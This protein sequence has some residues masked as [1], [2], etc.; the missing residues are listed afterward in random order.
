MKAH[1]CILLSIFAVCKNS[2]AHSHH[3]NQPHHRRTHHQ[4]NS[5]D[6]EVQAIARLTH[7]LH[8]AI[9][10]EHLH[11]HSVKDFL[12]IFRN[13][14]QWLRL[15]NFHKITRRTVRAFN[16]ESDKRGLANHAKNLALLFPLSHFIE[17]MTAPAF[18]A[19]GTI[20]ELPSIVIGFGGS[21]LSIIA[22]PGLDPLCI[23]LL[24]AYPFKPVHRSIDFIRG[25]VEK[26]VR[27]TA[28]A[29][30]L[31][32]LLSKTFTYKDRFHLI[33]KEFSEKNKL[34]RL[35]DIELTDFEGGGGLSI[36][37]KKN[38]DKM[39]SLKRVYDPDTNQFYIASIWISRTANPALIRSISNLLSWNARSAVN[40]LLK[41]KDSRH[42]MQSYEREFFVDHITVQDTGIEAVYKEKAINL[43]GLFQLKKTSNRLHSSPCK[44]HIS[45]PF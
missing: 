10:G 32:V 20:H 44:T 38:G 4:P 40:E 33:K 9:E 19:V 28:A 13:K 12:K 21:L 11:I 29:L 8:Q 30:K 43:K 14:E 45:K 6:T 1:L 3:D 41:I 37:S 39:L 34:N 16:L 24:S 15:L 27:S 23:L 26:G 42:K 36:S 18:I 25:F 22:V 17:V 2:L 5:T 35:F 31:D 7:I